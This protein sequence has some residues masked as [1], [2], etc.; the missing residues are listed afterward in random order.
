MIYD[1]KFALSSLDDDETIFKILIEEYI[2]NCDIQNEKI[3]NAVKAENFHEIH[4]EVH[5]M[6]GVFQTYGVTGCIPLMK[7]V[8]H[9]AKNEDLDFIKNNYMTIINIAK[10]LKEEFI[11]E[12]NS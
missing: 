11:K 9:A 12:L 2:K 6:K 5:S 3:I 4:L 1:K 8:I 10:E 7:E